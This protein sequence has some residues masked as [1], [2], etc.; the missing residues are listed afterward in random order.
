[1]FF[2]CQLTDGYQL[3]ELSTKL[4]TTYI[5]PVRAHYTRVLLRICFNLKHLAFATSDKPKW[6]LLATGTDSQRSTVF[7]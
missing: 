6:I 4:R 3:V 1:M 2:G 5:A 7:R